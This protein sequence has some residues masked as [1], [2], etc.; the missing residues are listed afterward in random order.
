MPR[1]VLLWLPANSSHRV[2]ISLLRFTSRFVFYFALGQRVIL[3]LLACC[4]HGNVI[5]KEKHDDGRKQRA[6]FFVLLSYKFLFHHISELKTLARLMKKYYFVHST[7]SLTSIAR[8]GQKSGTLRQFPTILAG[9]ALCIR[10]NQ[11]CPGQ[12]ER[13]SRYVVLIQFPDTGI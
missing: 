2:N 11:R 1:C 5:I 7:C 4:V 6:S 12:P 3:F 8:V 13:I 9:N 10:M